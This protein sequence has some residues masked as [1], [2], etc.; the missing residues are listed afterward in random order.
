MRCHNGQIFLSSS[1]RVH[2]LTTSGVF[3]GVE[4]PPPPPQGEVEGGSG[5]LS[6]G[7]R[8]KFRGGLQLTF[9]QRGRARNLKIGQV[10]A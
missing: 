2:I 5:R 1:G 3:P 6:W 4:V 7:R 10:R 8:C 9:R